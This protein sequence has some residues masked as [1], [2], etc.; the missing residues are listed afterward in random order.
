MNPIFEARSSHRYD[1]ADYL[2]VDPILGG[3]TA[4]MSLQNACEGRG[5]K[6]ILDRVFSHKGDDAR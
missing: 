3:T 2:N 1:T 5:I 4:F 6:I